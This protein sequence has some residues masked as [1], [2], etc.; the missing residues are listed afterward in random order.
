MTL[1]NPQPLE[2]QL[3]SHLHQ[4]GIPP[5]PA[6]LEQVI[7][8]LQQPNPDLRILA[9]IIST[10]A[11]IAAGLLK[12]VNSP[13]YGLPGKAQ[14]VQNAVHMLGLLATANAVASLALRRALPSPPQ[15]ERFWDASSK[16]AKLSGWLVQE[17]QLSPV[18]SADLAY[19]FGLFRDCGI[20]LMIRRFPEYYTTLEQAN[21]CSQRTFTEIE[22]ARHQTSHA[23]VGSMLAQSWWLPPDTILAIHHHHDLCLFNA[24]PSCLSRQSWTL[25]ALAQ[26]AEYLIQQTAG[27]SQTCEWEKMGSAIQTGLQL[28]DARI[29]KL[30]EQV[31]TLPLSAD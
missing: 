28:S 29:T 7:Q 8:R 23:L 21:H 12:T 11:G 17:L 10:N 4:N 14:T 9:D 5:R 1:L 26:L 15:L 20:P 25:I 18:L 16:I 3:L 22:E 19:T 13:F 2:E 27:Q 30:Q 31:R 24:A 6:I